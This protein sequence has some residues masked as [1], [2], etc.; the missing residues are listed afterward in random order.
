MD[1]QKISLKMY[2]QKQLED[3]VK[4]KLNEFQNQVDTMHERLKEEN[5][6][7]EHT[8]AERAIKQMELINQK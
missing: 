2:Y 4:Q 1:T 3:V 7:R 5:K 6:Q 8:I